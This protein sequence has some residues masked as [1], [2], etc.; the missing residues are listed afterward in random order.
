M[1]KKSFE[2]ALARL[3]QITE[4]LEGGEVTLETSLKRFNE[5]V[6]LASY[7]DEQLKHARAKVEMLMEKDGTLK[8]IPFNEGENNED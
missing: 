3:E 4:E 2:T 6:Q 7:C 8:T 1:P 5:G